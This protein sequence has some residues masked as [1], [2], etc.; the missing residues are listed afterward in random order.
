M[1]GM[2]MP[3]QEY[4]T[5]ENFQQREAQVILSSTGAALEYIAGAAPTPPRWAGRIGLE[6]MFR[7][8][9]EP[10]RLFSRYLIEPW[11][12]LLLLLMDYPRSRSAAKLHG[13]APSTYAASDEQSSPLQMRGD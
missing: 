12:I 4:W 1:V 8:A 7:L 9:H 13:R 5:Q 10:R 6:W 3:R 11:Y 2:G